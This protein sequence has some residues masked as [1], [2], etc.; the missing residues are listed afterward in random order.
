MYYR[1]R[2]VGRNPYFKGAGGEEYWANSRIV[3][4]KVKVDS[5]KLWLLLLFY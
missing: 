3:L 2:L 5:R 4:L 1:D